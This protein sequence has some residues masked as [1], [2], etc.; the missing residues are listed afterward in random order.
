RGHRRHRARHPHVSTTRRPVTRLPGELHGPTVRLGHPRAEAR[1]LQVAAG[2]RERVGDDDVRT[3]ADVV[4]VD[5]AEDVGVRE[6]GGPAPRLAVHGDA[7]T[8]E[9][10]SRAPVEDDDVAP[11]ET[12][13]EP[14]GAHDG[15]STPSLTGC[16]TGVETRPTARPTPLARTATTSAVRTSIA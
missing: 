6:D 5:A 4:L 3:R 1:R 15:P 11:R 12:F 9:L 7:A 2:T 13:V 8:L 14:V 10:G 16:R